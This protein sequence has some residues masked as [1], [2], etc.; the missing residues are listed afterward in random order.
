MIWGGCT[1]NNLSNDGLQEQK[2]REAQISREVSAA[3]QQINAEPLQEQQQLGA[4]QQLQSPVLMNAQQQLPVV[5]PDTAAQLDAAYAEVRGKQR[6]SKKEREKRMNVYESKKALSERISAENSAFEQSRVS[7]A[8][9]T[10]DSRGDDRSFERIGL[11]WLDFSG[12]EEAV[13]KNNA[14][15]ARLT[16]SD[17]QAQIAEAR[18]IFDEFLKMDISDLKIGTDAQLGENVQTR[19]DKLLK[20][21]E[22][23]QLINRMD[24][25]GAPI[26]EEQR[27]QL[28]AKK[29]TVISI[30]NHAEAYM[31]IIG[32]P[33][34]ALLRKADTADLTPDQ[35]Q[36]RVAAATIQHNQELADYYTNLIVLR[37]ESDYK[38]GQSVE[39]LSEREL[40][41]TKEVRSRQIV[42]ERRQQE[43]TAAQEMDE[44]QADFAMLKTIETRKRHEDFL[45]KKG[46]GAD[47]YLQRSRELDELYK[48][49]VSYPNV[50]NAPDMEKGALTAGGASRIVTR[51][52]MVLGIFFSRSGKTLGDPLTPEDR[53]Q[54]KKIQAEVDNVIEKDNTEENAGKLLYE[55]GRGMLTMVPTK[56]PLGS[57]VERRKNL[58]DMKTIMYLELDFV[59]L[60]NGNK[61]CA[62]N[63][64]RR[65]TNRDIERL[66]DMDAFYK[67]YSQAIVDYGKAI[68]DPHY[69]DYI[70]GRPMDAEQ[71]ENIETMLQ[72]GEYL[73]QNEPLLA[74]FAKQNS[75]KMRDCPKGS[76]EKLL[77]NYTDKVD[78]IDVGF[79]SKEDL[80][81]ER[82]VDEKGVQAYFDG[83]KKIAKD[84]IAKKAA[85]EE[86][87]QST[88]RGLLSREADR[89]LKSYEKKAASANEQA[90]KLGKLD[91]DLQ[92]SLS[93]WLDH[94]GT[95]EAAKANKALY[96]KFRSKDKAVRYAA[97]NDIFDRFLA[98]D[99]SKLKVGTNEDFVSH[100]EENM[101]LIKR[102]F[103]IKL[104]LEKAKQSGMPVD[105]EREMQIRARGDL[106][107]NANKFAGSFATVIRNRN[108]ALTDDQELLKLSTD[109]LAKRMEAAGQ[110]G[111]MARFDYFAN[112]LQVHESG[113]FTRGS[114]P[115]EL[116]D[117]FYAARVAKAQ[118]DA[119]NA[120]QGSNQ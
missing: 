55:M 112:L 15:M 33:Y 106:F 28:L 3:P 20:A 89:Q 88:P 29:N 54:I 114:D 41:E 78:Q 105:P 94:S 71:R 30:D 59:Q 66:C 97:F 104:T 110:D 65:F 35:L 80:E 25:I 113:E 93:P 27:V 36:D 109:E 62:D 17:K 119:A 118:K 14:R 74:K 72:G 10:A 42:E 95:P 52:S 13:A 23:E 19:R 51:K 11:A 87:Q 6:M 37:G 116:L 102:G 39:E 48:D 75:F 1:I 77:N 56:H 24:T 53:E 100:L 4:Q 103:Q 96:D 61:A 50:P 84:Q 67:F 98:L 70:N 8:R 22:I 111:D 9:K 101:E 63:M 49:I 90:G 117:K 34:Y 31:K 76:Y 115:K 91:G 57:E 108:F 73:K 43:N 44:T 7:A 2:K 5:I 47:A 99:I 12:G 46:A 68:G 58:A 83:C 79:K 64:Y 26:D 21:M 85:W 40:A 92:R 32:S 81:A 45:K 69:M 107:E 86:Q 38:R 82:L 120:S 16:S 60:C 18:T